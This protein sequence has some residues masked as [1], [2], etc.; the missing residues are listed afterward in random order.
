MTRN[1]AKLND[2]TKEFD[3]RLSLCCD[4]MTKAWDEREKLMNGIVARI[5]HFQVSGAN[6]LSRAPSYAYE[7]GVCL[8]PGIE[9]SHS[10]YNGL[11]LPLASG[12]FVA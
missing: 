3:K 11:H 7:I 5:V 10:G 12:G 9:V 6:S 1:T 8:A 4:A 2:V